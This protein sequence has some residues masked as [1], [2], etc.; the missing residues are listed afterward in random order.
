MLKN[1]VCQRKNIVYQKFAE[2]IRSSANFYEVRTI[3][4]VLV[5]MCILQEMKLQFIEI[6]K[7]YIILSLYIHRLIV[8]V[9]HAK[10]VEIK[11]MYHKPNRK[12]RNAL[13]N[14]QPQMKMRR[15]YFLTITCFRYLTVC[16]LLLW[17][18]QL[19]NF[20]ITVSGKF[21]GEWFSRKAP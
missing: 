16:C 17:L 9:W 5:N 2:D 15:N 14:H 7:F 21:A 3:F 20:V 12:H 19:F 4:K 11:L 18:L 13:S 10:V 6:L 8:A 1:W